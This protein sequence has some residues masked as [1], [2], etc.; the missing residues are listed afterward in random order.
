MARPGIR[1]VREADD[2]SQSMPDRN[3]FLLMEAE[4]SGRLSRGYIVARNGG[5]MRLFR[6]ATDQT[7]TL[8]RFQRNRRFGDW[9]APAA[10]FSMDAR[11]PRD[12]GTLLVGTGTPAVSQLH[13][14]ANSPMW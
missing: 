1:Y 7:F 3:P 2:Q 5:I 6:A 9:Y 13:E 10:C 11:L 12:C 14:T 4:A 8:V